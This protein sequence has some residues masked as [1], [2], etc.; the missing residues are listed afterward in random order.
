VN[1]A[2]ENHATRQVSLTAKGRGGKGGDRIRGHLGG[3]K[4]SEWVIGDGG[5]NSTSAS[6]ISVG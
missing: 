1:L 3:R 5:R 6:Y 2:E 4:T